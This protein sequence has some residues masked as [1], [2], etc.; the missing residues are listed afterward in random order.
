[1]FRAASTLAVVALPLIGCREP[2]APSRADLVPGRYAVV[3]VN[4]TALPTVIIDNPTLHI[5]LLA[6]TLIIDTD[7]DGRWNSHYRWFS[8][9]EP[10]TTVHLSVE[11]SVRREEGVYRLRQIPCPPE[12]ICE[13]P[14]P[15]DV[16][17]V[18]D[19]LEAT[20]RFGTFRWQRVAPVD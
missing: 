18:G 16:R 3:S 19:T 7:G 5:S 10:P 8:D 1:M 9:V 17:I 4:G 20:A 2:H 13:V 15:A 14:P 6:D 11:V 12:L